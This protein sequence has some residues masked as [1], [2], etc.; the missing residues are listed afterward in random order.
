MRLAYTILKGEISSGDQTASVPFAL[1]FEEE[2]VYQIETFLPDKTYFEVTRNKEWHTLKGTTEKNFEIEITY[3]WYRRFSFSNMKLEM[4]CAGHLKLQNNKEGDA[5]DTD[6]EDHSCH[7]IELTGLAMKMAHHTEVKRYRNGTKM[8]GLEPINFD[9]TASTMIVNFS[10]TAGNYYHLVFTPKNGGTIQL[11]F[12]QDRGYNK[13][14]YKNYLLI[15][16]AL[17]SFLSFMNGADVQ[18]KKELTGS[19]VTRSNGDTI[20]DAQTVYHYSGKKD[21]IIQR[22][23]FLPIASHHSCTSRIVPHLFIHCFDKFYALDKDLDLMATVF[24]LNN[25]TQTV[26]MMERFYI[27]MTSLEKLATSYARMNNQESKFW[28]D[29]TLFKDSI[30]PQLQKA[31]SPFRSQSEKSDSTDWEVLSSRLNNLNTKN[32]KGTTEKLYSLLE[33]AG[34]KVN[35]EIEHLINIQRNLS[36]HEGKTGDSIE[37]S[38]SNYW[39][40]D[41]LL[42]DIILNLIGYDRLRNH[43]YRYYEGD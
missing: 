43:Y 7:T 17:I 8:Q 36:V 19:F 25:A 32:K 11:D 6:G 4:V 2:G 40:L 20:V 22:S 12:T 33:F 27:L 5:L 23:D 39:K 18:V 24:A 30:L 42:R 10:R 21:S 37:H 1:V 29:D 13:M 16:P 3:I 41:H 14:T 26:G 28:V 9:H 31:L 34:I 15:K 35:K 38:I